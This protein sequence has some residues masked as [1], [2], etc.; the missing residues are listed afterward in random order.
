MKV[1]KSGQTISRL[2]RS[3]TLYFRLF[4][5]IVSPLQV[6]FVVCSICVFMVFEWSRIFWGMLWSAAIPRSFSLSFG[7]RPRGILRMRLRFCV[8]KSFTF[9]QKPFACLYAV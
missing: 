5:W 4:M 2:S 1:S 8:K 7:L 9:C 6:C 3:R